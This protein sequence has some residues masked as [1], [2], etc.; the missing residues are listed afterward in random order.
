LRAILSHQ[1]P[2]ATVKE[3]LGFAVKK[4]LKVLRTKEPR[5]K[6]D[7]K[8]KGETE[9]DLRQELNKK[10][11]PALAVKSSRYIPVE[12][13]RRVWKRDGGQCSFKCN[14]RNCTSTHYLEFDHIV[15]FALGGQATVEN[16]R[17][18][19]RAHNQLAAVAAFGAKKD[20]AV[21]T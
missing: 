5:I 7:S 16:L 6:L 9:K 17:V 1:M 3:V 21:R 11:P 18:R 14:G 8:L 12:I 4:T 13:K 2:V 20:G 19:C 15:P 10:S